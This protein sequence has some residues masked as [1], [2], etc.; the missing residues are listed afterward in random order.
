MPDETILLPLG[1]TEEDTA[2]DLQV[3][4][5]IASGYEWTCPNCDTYNT[6]TA[7]TLHVECHQCGGFFETNP[8]AHAYD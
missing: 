2:D 8:P 6:M 3:V 4:D 7:H 1:Q 5:V